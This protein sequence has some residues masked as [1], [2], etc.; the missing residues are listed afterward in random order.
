MSFYGN[1]NQVAI[2]KVIKKYVSLTEK[3]THSDLIQAS[4]NIQ[5]NFFATCFLL[6]CNPVV[7]VEYLLAYNVRSKF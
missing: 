7:F 5:V 2:M 3:N 1:V 4:D 6:F